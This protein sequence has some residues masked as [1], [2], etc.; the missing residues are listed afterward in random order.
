MKTIPHSKA[1]FTLIELL[2]VISIIAILAGMLLPVL[3]KA[4]DRAKAARARVE[5][6]QIMTAINQYE[7]DYHRLPAWKLTRQ[8]GAEADFTY[9]T[10][11]WI[12][13][14]YQQLVRFGK[15][16]RGPQSMLVPIY[17]PGLPGDYRN[18]NAELMFILTATAEWPNAAGQMVATANEDH[19]LNPKRNVYL[20]VNRVSQTTSGGMGPDGIYRD[21]WGNPY[22][23]TLDLSGDGRCRDAF[24]RL[25]RVSGMSGAL[26]YN[27]LSRDTTQ[28]PAG[29]FFEASKSVMI[30]SLGADGNADA[31]VNANLGAN[32]DNILSWQ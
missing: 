16:P 28:H 4:K 26:G 8:V 10:F 7:S 12:G 22:I 11:H 3:S 15:P 5:I 18:S 31:T 24:Y 13:T 2:V 9:G 20:D 30:W 21:P 1:G 14:T 23:V 32:K 17:T 27:G 19:G 25:E 29:D 6:N